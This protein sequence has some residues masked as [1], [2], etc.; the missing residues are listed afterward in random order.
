MKQNRIKQVVK[1]NYDK[2][3]DF[4]NIPDVEQY[5]ESFMLR[6]N[7]IINNLLFE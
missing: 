4:I 3:I 6:K 7:K 2:N 5:S 1:D